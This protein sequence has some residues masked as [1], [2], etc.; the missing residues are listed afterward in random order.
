MLQ[1]QQNLGRRFRTRLPVNCIKGTSG[2]G[3]CPFEGGCSVIVD[4]FFIVASIVCGGSVF[5][6]RFCYSVLYVIIALQSS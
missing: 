2:L 1:Q 4:L 3:W 5:G 6:P